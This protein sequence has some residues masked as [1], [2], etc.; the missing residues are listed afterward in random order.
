MWSFTTAL[1]QGQWN[2]FVGGLT[3]TPAPGK[4]GVSLTPTFAWN[5]ADWTNT[6]EFVL[7]KDP[8]FTIVVVS[9][10]VSRAGTGTCRP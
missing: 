3:E 1:G 8:A 6:Y 7:A 5:A 4:T 10:M 9:K 2:P